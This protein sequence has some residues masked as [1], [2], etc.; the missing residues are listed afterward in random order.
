[1]HEFW[2]CHQGVEVEILQINGAV[3]SILCGDDA[4]EVK[5]DHDHVN[6]GGTAIPRVGDVI[7]QW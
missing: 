7:F 1:M 5:F 2:A 6:G 4:G 3:A